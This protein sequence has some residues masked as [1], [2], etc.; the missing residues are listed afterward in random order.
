[1][2]C[3]MLSDK[4]RSSIAATRRKPSR[5]SKMDLYRL[6]ACTAILGLLGSPAQSESSCGEL[7]KYLRGGNDAFPS[8]RDR[9]LPGEHR[10]TVHT[11]LLKG[12]CE[13]TAVFNP[14]EFRMSCRFNPGA[15]NAVRL[16]SF[17]SLGSY[18]QTCLNGQDSRDEWRKRD[19]S[20]TEYNGRVITET[21][22]T[23]TWLS[24]RIERQIL[25]S[26]DSG[27]PGEPKKSENLLVVIWRALPKD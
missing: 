3:S 5:K 22:W 24:N 12:N 20:R 7:E 9:A 16:A 27:D 17:Q 8:N 14:T 4:R 21:T 10:W 26:S 25:V 23:W 18:V 15:A 6:A 19:T 13:L 2:M 1:M 11:P